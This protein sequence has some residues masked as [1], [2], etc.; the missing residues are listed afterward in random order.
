MDKVRTELVYFPPKQFSPRFGDNFFTAVIENY[1]RV[2]PI[3][4]CSGHYVVYAIGVS[5][6]KHTWIVKRRFKEFEQLLLY[7]KGKYPNTV[8]PFPALPAKT[9]CSVLNDEDFLLARS[10]ELQTFLH[11]MLL[12]LHIE[13]VLLDDK[14]TEFLELFTVPKSTYASI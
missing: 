8:Q 4:S 14:V 6:G 2:K 10:K 12:T 5:R 9:C 7:L 1:E 11:E 13:K 3:D